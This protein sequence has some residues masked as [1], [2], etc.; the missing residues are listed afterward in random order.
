MRAQDSRG[1]IERI[2]MVVVWE[3]GLGQERRRGYKQSLDAGEPARPLAWAAACLPSWGS[4]PAGARA[5]RLVATANA[6]FRFVVLIFAPRTA[7]P[8][9]RRLRV[10]CAVCRTHRRRCGRWFGAVRDA[11]ACPLR[12]V[13]SGGRGRSFLPGRPS[14][15]RCK[16]SSRHRRTP[17][18]AQLSRSRSRSPTPPPPG[19]ERCVLSAPRSPCAGPPSSS[20]TKQRQTRPLSCASRPRNTAFKPAMACSPFPFRL[21][22]APVCVSGQPACDSKRPQLRRRL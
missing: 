10:A 6:A 14:S 20:M 3:A 15:R 12:A 5:T 19:A 21:H 16:R 9:H 7:A 2:M 22:H 11:A 4:H 8:E 13:V 18:Q 17:G 1:G